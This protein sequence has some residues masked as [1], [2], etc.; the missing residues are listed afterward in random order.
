[1]QIDSYCDQSSKGC[2][3]NGEVIDII[4]GHLKQLEPEFYQ[5]LSA[6]DGMIV[7][8]RRRVVANPKCAVAREGGYCLSRKSIMRRAVA[9]LPLR[10]KALVGCTQECYGYFGQCF[11]SL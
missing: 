9:R 10:L 8:R 1:M 6:P 2:Y 4:G 3:L 7:S 5:P 11:F